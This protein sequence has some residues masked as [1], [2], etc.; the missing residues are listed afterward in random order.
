MIAPSL[1]G[2]TGLFIRNQLFLQA[3][4][5]PLCHPAFYIRIFIGSIANVFP[6][7]RPSIRAKVG[8]TD[9]PP[10]L[11]ILLTHMG[12][13][14]I[15]SGCRIPIDSQIAGLYPQP[16]FVIG[17]QETCTVIFRPDHPLPVFPIKILCLQLIPF[18]VYIAYHSIVCILAQGQLSLY[19]LI[20]GLHPVSALIIV[21]FERSIP[22]S[23]A[24]YRF[25]HIICLIICLSNK[26]RLLQKLTG[27]GIIYP[28]DFCKTIVVPVP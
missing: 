14:I 11:V 19:I 4:I 20:P 2:A 8:F 22:I 26:V 23:L 6:Y 1:Y 12:A 15:A 3:I 18:V 16:P 24:H 21:L 28:V 25:C 13:A 7:N 9:Q 5:S 17:E 10:R 27:S